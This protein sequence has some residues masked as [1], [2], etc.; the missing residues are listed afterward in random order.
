MNCRI[1]KRATPRA[2]EP[3]GRAPRAKLQST[4]RARW[5]GDV[6]DGIPN[7]DGDT[8]TRMQSIRSTRF[9]RV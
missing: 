2:A 5:G 6:V 9:E 8:R 3:A 4:H 7:L 1:A